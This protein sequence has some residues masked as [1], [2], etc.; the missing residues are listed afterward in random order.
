MGVAGCNK[1]GYNKLYGGVLNGDDGTEIAMQ[2]AA[3]GILAKIGGDGTGF[4][5]NRKIFHERLDKTAKEYIQLGRLDVGYSECRKL[6]SK[7]KRTNVVDVEQ[8]VISTGA[9]YG[10]SYGVSSITGWRHIGKGMCYRGSGHRKIY[11][12]IYYKD[13]NT[14]YIYH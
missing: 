9:G 12:D 10:V 1:C 4:D 5:K 2:A 3:S 7:F 8:T 13:G 11:Y 14:Q 6:K